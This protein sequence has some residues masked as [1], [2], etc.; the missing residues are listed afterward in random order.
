M[1]I[2]LIVINSQIGKI[3][4][5]IYQVSNHTI[6]ELKC[7]D[8]RKY[9]GFSSRMWNGKNFTWI[10]TIILDGEIACFILFSS[11]SLIRPWILF[12]SVVFI[13]L[14]P[15]SLILIEDTIPPLYS[16]LLQQYLP[17]NSL[18]ASKYKHPII[19]KYQ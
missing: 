12:I 8:E 16:Q 2:I 10:E 15:Y 19:S 13:E 14:A 7:I 5:W 1:Q 6:H 17:I 18:L 4:H 3:L 11:R 9:E